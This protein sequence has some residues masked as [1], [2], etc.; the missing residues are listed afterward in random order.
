MRSVQNGRETKN[1]GRRWTSVFGLSSSLLLLLIAIGCGNQPR[2]PG[3]TSVK[4][5]VREKPASQAQDDLAVTATDPDHTDTTKPADSE[6]ATETKGEAVVQTGDLSDA[7]RQRAKD[8]YK[9][10]CST[11]H[12]DKGDGVSVASRFLFP[13]PRNFRGGRFRLVST[14][15]AVPTLSLIHI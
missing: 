15:N 1:N 13:K 5:T 12:G 4:P 8:L 3:G 9:T 10:H 14:E 7:Q 2:P 11:C 6:P